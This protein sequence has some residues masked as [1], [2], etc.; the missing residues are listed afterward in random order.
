MLN[1]IARESNI[2]HLTF[3]LQSHNKKETKLEWLKLNSIY[4]KES[5]YPMQK[6]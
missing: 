4:D 1:Q 2:Y 6:I 5:Y 3:L